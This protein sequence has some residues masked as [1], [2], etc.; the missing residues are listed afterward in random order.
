MATYRVVCTEREA[1]NAHPYV[2]RIL[3]IGAN[4]EGGTGATSRWLVREVVTALDAG[5]VF[6]THGEQSGKTARVVKYW[7]TPCAQWHIRSTPDA[8]RD[9]NLDDL[10]ACAWKAA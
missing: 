4:D 6:Y 3:A 8:V 2:G 5:H 1:A 10:R 7:C 9:D